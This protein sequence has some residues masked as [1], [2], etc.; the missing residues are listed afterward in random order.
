MITG[1][2]DPSPCVSPK[3]NYLPNIE[4]LSEES[5]S[6]GDNVVATIELSNIGNLQGETRVRVFLVE[7]GIEI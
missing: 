6:P 2:D 3:P 4:P 7:Q 5:T 1:P